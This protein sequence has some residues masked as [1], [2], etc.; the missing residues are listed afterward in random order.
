MKKKRFSIKL[1]V[2][3]FVY[4]IFFA[5]I[6]SPFYVLYGPFSGLKKGI[7]GMVNASRHK[8]LL[9]YVYSQKQIDNILGIVQQK[10]VDTAKEDVSQIDVKFKN[11]TDITRFNINTTKFDGYVLE[12]KNPLRVKVAMTS[13]L[14][15]EGEKTSEM[16][17]EKGAIAAIN[18]GAFVDNAKNGKAYTGTGAYPGGFVI[19]GGKVIYKQD[20]VRDTDVENVTAFTDVG[21][22]IVGDHTLKELLNMHVTE[23]ICFRDPTL[24]INSKKQLTDPQYGGP[25]P[26]TAVGQKADG[27]VILVVTDGRKMFPKIGGT[28]YDMQEIMAE[29]GAVNASNLDGGYSS[30]MYYDGDLINSPNEWDGERTVATSIYVEP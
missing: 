29:H 21:K 6:T 28:L 20:G 15:V 24:I 19:S 12:I 9:S 8:Y 2:L 10:T 7:V 25:N 3:G 18:G 16:A 13:K 11:S 5:A 23:A 22:L 4:M 27:T 30:A 26:M 17:K 14:G 1:F